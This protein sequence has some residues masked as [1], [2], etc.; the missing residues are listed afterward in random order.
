MFDWSCALELL[1]PQIVTFIAFLLILEASFQP[2]SALV[3]GK[4][5]APQRYHRHLGIFYLILQNRICRCDSVKDFKMGR[6]Y[7]GLFRWA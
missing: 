3:A 4:I 6:D 2:I 5:M 1:V 7:P